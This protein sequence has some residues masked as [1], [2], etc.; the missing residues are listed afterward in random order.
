MKR[1]IISEW[2]KVFLYG[3]LIVFVY[4]SALKQLIWNDWG[5]EDYTHCAIIP[6]VILYLI[7]E[8]RQRLASMASSPSWLGLMPFSCGIGLFW[9][10]E[11]GGEFFSMYISLW[12]VVVGLLWLH[13][14]WEKIKVMVFA[15]FIALS[16]FPFPNFIN[17][18][19]LLKLKLISSQLGVV[20]LHMYGMS[21]HREGNVI[22]IGFTQLQ[23]VDACSGMRYVLPMAVLSLIMAYWYRAAFWKK[24][25]VVASSIPLAV[26]VNSLRIALTGILYRSWGADVAEGFFHD[27]AGWLIFMITLPVLLLEMWVL[28]KIGKR[29]DT[30]R[31]DAGEV[32]PDR[33]LPCPPAEMVMGDNKKDLASDEGRGN[34]GKAM[35]QPVF[36]TAMVVLIATFGLSHGVEFREKIPINKSLNGF[37]MAIGE[38]SGKQMTMEVNILESLHLSDYIMAAYHNPNGRMIDFYVAYYESQ[39]KGEAMHSPETCLPGGGWIFEKS[40]IKTIAKENG[41]QLR[42]NRVFAT[43]NGSRQ[44]VYFWFPQRGRILTSLYQVKFYTFWDALTRQRTDGALVR[45]ITEVYSG[46]TVEAAEKRMVDFIS[47]FNPVLNEYL[48]Q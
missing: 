40:S 39:R 44:L 15:I 46:E 2:L 33:P 25:V 31:K 10:G 38:W 28:N 30:E 48:P 43:N 21:A 35:L 32:E 26:L 36:I 34:I 16:M 45:L 7:W 3:L 37:P 24:A 4:Q 47:E 20:M 14:G 23:V 29:D 19:V 5:R 17:S 11:L 13:L 1:I 22:D 8:K 27:F 41:K 6:F 42:L 9:L 12:F 18:K